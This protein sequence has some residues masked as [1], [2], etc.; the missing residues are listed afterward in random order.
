MFTV[1]AAGLWVSS[2]EC[3][4]TFLCRLLPFFFLEEEKTLKQGTEND[5]S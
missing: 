3:C 4:S 1:Y 2:L 5:V